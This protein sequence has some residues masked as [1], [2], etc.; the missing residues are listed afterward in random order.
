MEKKHRRRGHKARIPMDQGKR[1]RHESAA[2]RRHKIQ[3][4]PE[5]PRALV[6][7]MGCEVAPPRTSKVR[8]YFIFLSS[9]E[10]FLKYICSSATCPIASLIPHVL[11]QGTA[12]NKHEFC[13]RISAKR[14]TR[15]VNPTN[16]CATDSI[17]AELQMQSTLA[18]KLQLKQVGL[19]DTMS[20]GAATPPGWSVQQVTCIPAIGYSSITP[21][22]LQGQ[23]RTG[24]A[25]G[26]DGL[27]EGFEDLNGTV[28]TGIFNVPPLSVE[29]DSRDGDSGGYL[30]M[31]GS[32]T[33]N[34]TSNEHSD[35]EGTTSD[36]GDETEIQQ[37]ISGGFS[38]HESSGLIL[39]HAADHIGVQIF[40]DY[41]PA[42]LSTLQI[43]EI[44][45]HHQSRVW[46][47]LWR[48]HRMQVSAPDCSMPELVCTAHQ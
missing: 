9:G 41:R 5:L 32:D 35:K 43:L 47:H 40:F 39:S 36:N 21:L 44:L 24:P 42:T 19:L 34:D 27:L 12:K 3:R 2:G 10:Y 30:N 16:P 15:V 6:K 13:S 46:R 7:E 48:M 23:P 25:D 1:K 29:E 17:E 45:S 26:L 28:P 33:D 31:V 4:G 11:M 18:K 37:S 20:S 14:P 38:L 22:V 8:L